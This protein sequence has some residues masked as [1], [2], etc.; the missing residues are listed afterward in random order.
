MNH[1]AMYKLSYGLYIVNHT[2]CRE[3]KRLYRQYRDPGG[4]HSESD[5]RL[6]QQG[7]LYPRYAFKHRC[8]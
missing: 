2:G 5:L 8:I 3:D 6:H 7:K 1:K 4:F